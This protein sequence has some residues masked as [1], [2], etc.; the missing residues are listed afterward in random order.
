LTERARSICAEEQ[1]AMSAEAGEGRRMRIVMAPGRGQLGAILVHDMAA[2]NRGLSSA[3]LGP[4]DQA[5]ET[6]EARLADAVARLGGLDGLALVAAAALPDPDFVC[7]PEAWD[8]V[9][10]ENTRAVWLSIK[11]AYP[12]LKQSKGAVT[13]IVPAAAA[14][15][16]GDDLA[17]GAS[18]AATILMARVFAQ[19]LARDDIRVNVVMAGSTSGDGVAEAALFLLGPAASYISGQVLPVDGGL[20][21]RAALAALK[22]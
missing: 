21:D 1:G 18:L 8:A 13:V 10:E 7:T 12:Y 15:P 22:G 6:I 17:Q 2:S 9:G 11:A 19:E 20:I 4:A 16:D 14:I 3:V 5:P